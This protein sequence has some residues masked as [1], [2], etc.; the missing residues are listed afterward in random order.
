MFDTLR[1]GN[2]A[3]KEIY[4]TDNVQID[5]TCMRSLGEYIK[6][7][8]SIE[9]IWLFNNNISDTGIEILAPF[10]NGNATLRILDLNS[11]K[12]I[13]DKS[14][15]FLVKIIET[16]HVENIEI[17]NTEITH[18]NSLLWPLIF[19]RLKYGSDTLDLSEK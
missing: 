16:S 1:A 14:I 10:F 12:K 11:N 5:D 8:K 15:P 9:K 18:R 4:W 19:N 7:N 6:F 17:K 2:S 3:I 13:T